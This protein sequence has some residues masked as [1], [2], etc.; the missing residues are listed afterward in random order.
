MNKRVTKTTATGSQNAPIYKEP[1]RVSLVKNPTKVYEKPDFNA[2]EI[3][4]L[5][6]GNYTI[7]AETTVSE[8]L[9]GALST[10]LGWIPLNNCA[11]LD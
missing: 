9:W 5:R 11:R 6:G 2:K 8:T 1:Y 4:S 3:C 10:G 7:V